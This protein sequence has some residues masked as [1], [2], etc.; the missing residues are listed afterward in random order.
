MKLKIICLLVAI[1]CLWSVAAHADDRETA[2]AL[3]QKAVAFYKTNGVEKLIDEVSNPKGQFVSGALYVFVM[4][5][6]AVMLAHPFNSSL[7]G[8]PQA[9]VRDADGKFMTREMVEIAKT[10]G[11]GWVDYR[12]KNPKTDEIAPKSTYVELT[13]ELMLGCGF[14]KK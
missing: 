9:A 8:Q 4:D 5:K 11:S 7:I 1:V 12:F 14:Y 13:D 3:V 2:V 10:K 6:D